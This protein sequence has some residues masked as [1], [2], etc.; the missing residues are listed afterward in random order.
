MLSMPG[1]WKGHDHVSNFTLD[2][3]EKPNFWLLLQNYD[4]DFNS[5]KSDAAVLWP[6]AFQFSYEVP[7]PLGVVGQGFF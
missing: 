2:Y 4:V 5:I 6:N 1:H 7:R 3:I